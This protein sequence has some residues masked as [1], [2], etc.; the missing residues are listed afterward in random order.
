MDTGNAT[1][2]RHIEA[3]PIG[4]PY[5]HDGPPTGFGGTQWTT[6]RYVLIKVTTEDGLV[7]WGEGFGYNVQGA[8][9]DVLRNTLAP[10]A[11]GKDAADIAGLMSWLKHTLHLFGRAGPTQ[12]A[13]GGLDI[14]LWDLAGKRA[15]VPV[16][17]LL[18]GR[19]RTVIPAYS[20]LMRMSDPQG[21]AHACER[22]LTK[23]FTQVK[24][25]EHTVAAVAAARETLGPDIA[26]MLDVNCAWTLNEAMSIAP[27]LAPYSLK[28]LEE[29]LYPPEDFAS[30]ARL[31]RSANVP[32]AAGENLPNAW[33]F[34]SAIESQALDYLQPSVTKVGGI[35]EFRTIL[36]LAEMHGHAVAPHSPYFGPG[37]L[38]TIHLA[39]F[40]PLIGA[41]ESFGLTLHAPLFGAIGLPDSQGMIGVPDAPGL[42]ADP[43]PD[44][45]ER[46]TIR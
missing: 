16:S 46:F 33:A 4:L 14:A 40:S 5:T 43:D 31:R 45:V 1:R 38:A 15:G 36:T 21:V 7:G 2:I 34:K 24:L 11:I 37:L 39:A 32:L 10:L 30:L 41:I 9:V 27:Q 19:S 23:G 6:L 28:W 13:L 25:H 44:I 29:P 20:S 22:L 18:G 12:Y 42:G 3:I 17:T 35:S 26:L 8:T